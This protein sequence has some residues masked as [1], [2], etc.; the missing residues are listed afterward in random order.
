MLLEQGDVAPETLD[1][2]GR[3]PLSSGARNGYGGIVK[4]LLKQGDASPDPTDNSDQT[5][6][7]WAAWYQ[8]SG[9]LGKLLEKEDVPNT[10]D[11]SGR[12]PLSW[13]AQNGKQ[14][15]LKILLE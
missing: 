11:K 10:A 7:W 9:V 1:K 5:L 14:Y 15:L 13:A 2:D 4:I 6:H 8:N 3:T 12:T